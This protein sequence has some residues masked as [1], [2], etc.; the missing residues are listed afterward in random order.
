MAGAFTNDEEA[1]L[2]MSKL[3]DPSITADS[4]QAFRDR[5]MGVPSAAPPDES[6]LYGRLS[7]SYGP[8]VSGAALAS[9]VGPGALGVLGIG[10]GANGLRRNLMGGSSHGDNGAIDF[11]DDAEPLRP[12]ASPGVNIEPAPTLDPR[13]GRAGAVGAN[14]YGASPGGGLKGAWDKAQQRQLGT[15]DDQKNAEA[16]LGAAKE[17]RIQKVGDLQEINANRM[18]RDAEIQQKADS[19]ASARF[20]QY[21]DTSSKYVDEVRNAKTDPGRLMRNADGGM[22]MNIAMG[23]ISGGMLSA[24]NGGSNK[25]MDHLDKV[26]DRDIR[27]QQDAVENQKFAVGARNTTFG[28][29]LAEHGDSRLAEMQTRNLMYEAMKTKFQAD[30]DRLGIPEVRANNVLAINAIDQKQAAMDEEF[31]KHAYMLAQQQAAAA[32][33]AQRAA[34]ERVWQHQKDV[35]EM[36]HKTDELQVRR[37]EIGAKGAARPLT[38]YDKALQERN[39]VL[40]SIDGGIANVDKLTAGTSLDAAAAHLP[41]WMP[42]VTGS[43]NRTNTRKDYNISAM[44]AVGAAYKLGTD[45]T[46]PKRMELLEH[47]SEPYVINPTDNREVALQKMNALKKLVSE[48]AEA[49]GPVSPAAPQMPGTV[50]VAK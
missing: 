49:K 5:V 35:F 33:A 6:T 15:L 29:M 32:A 41:A 37:E 40:K 20:Q 7:G 26:I 8:A 18:Q 11:P 45:S 17:E 43:T 22:Q 30:S 21:L 3:T 39:A 4:G 34:E 14:G 48:S 28:Q 44:M 24:L 42:G 10:L 46:E 23:S 47:Y 50:R 27:A 1:G 2:L 31:K 13:Y 25:F 12:M 16:N 9:T 36:G 38:E 19:D